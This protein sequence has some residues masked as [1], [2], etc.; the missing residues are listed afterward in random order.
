MKGRNYPSL[1]ENL[2]YGRPIDYFRRYLRY[3]FRRLLLFVTSSHQL[4][5]NK[6]LNLF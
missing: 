5:Y 4:H 6:Q 1:G 2:Y 3:D